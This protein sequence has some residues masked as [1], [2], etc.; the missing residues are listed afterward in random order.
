MKETGT[1]VALQ[2]ALFLIVLGAAAPLRAQINSSP[3]SLDVCNRGTVPVV[4]L[5]AMKYTDFQRGLGKHSWEIDT[6]VVA[7][8]KCRNVYFDMQ[9]DPIDLAFAFQDAKGQWGSGKIAQVPDFGTYN[10]WLK[11]TPIM[12]KGDGA[13]SVCAPLVDTSYK[14]DDNPKIDCTTMQLTPVN[15]GQE[16]HGPFVPVTS[17]LH[18]EDQGDQCFD[19][20]GVTRSVRSCNFYLNISPGGTDGELHAVRGTSGGDDADPPMTDA[21]L[22]KALADSPIMKALAKAAADERQKQAQAAAAAAAEREREAQANTPEGRL[23]KAREQQAA[24]E[25][26]Q[27]QILAAD[28]AGNPNVKDEA[29]MIRREQ[30]DNR[31]RW[32]GGLQSPAA[33][34]PQWMGKNVAVV[35]T[36]SRVEVDPNGSPQWVTIYFKESPNATFV[37][38]SPYPDL[39]Q[40]RVGLNL[41]ALVGKTLEAAGQVES[42]YCGGNAPKGSIRVVESKQWQ[43]R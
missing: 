38:C 7:S 35:G 18:F 20:A 19:G 26:R 36:V 33:Y 32:A 21:Q 1:R 25:Q 3:V 40:E 5:T 41:S 30:E 15:G 37:V 39:F 43:V 34:E 8:G 42:P 27:K 28:A 24:R 9:A 2:T 16:V 31:Q 23:K 11:N 29:Q 17:V 10:V 6:K 22:A 4:V 13:I 14:L 12:S